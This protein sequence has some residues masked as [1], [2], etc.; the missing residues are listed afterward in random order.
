MVLWNHRVGGFEG[1]DSQPS[2][3]LSQSFRVH[4]LWYLTPFYLIGVEFPVYSLQMEAYLDILTHPWALRTALMATVLI[5]C[6]CAL[7]RLWFLAVLVALGTAILVVVTGGDFLEPQIVGTLVGSLAAGSVWGL[8]CWLLREM[9]EAGPLQA[10]PDPRPAIRLEERDESK[11][12]STQGEL[13]AVF[14]E[15][16]KKMDLAEVQKKEKLIYHLVEARALGCERLHFY[17][18]RLDAPTSV[19]AIKMSIKSRLEEL[20]GGSK[21]SVWDVLTHED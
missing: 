2:G 3:L 9:K 16:L 15:D 6:F 10:Q 5:I 11:R 14:Q 12:A 4:I 7:V 18:M 13:L 8:T 21:P 19:P 20:G 17:D 1:I